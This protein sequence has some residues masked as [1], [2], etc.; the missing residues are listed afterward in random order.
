MLL[1]ACLPVRRRWL[2][3]WLSR[4]GHY[5]S[6][7]PGL[8]GVL[9]GRGVPWRDGFLLDASGDEDVMRLDDRVFVEFGECSLHRAR[10]CGGFSVSTVDFIFFMEIMF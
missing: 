2:V 10:L 6:S 4:S 8:A 1:D 3:Y 7:F 5:I 9:S